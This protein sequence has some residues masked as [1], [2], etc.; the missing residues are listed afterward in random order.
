MTSGLSK[1][2]E[3]TCWISCGARESHA[4]YPHPCG[5]DDVAPFRMTGVSFPLLS[6]HAPCGYMQKGPFELP[7]ASFGPMK[8]LF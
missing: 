4:D 1:G 3:L 8:T 2:D 7:I 6:F 5:L